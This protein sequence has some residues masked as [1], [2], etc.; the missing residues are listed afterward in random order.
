MDVS[1]DDFELREDGVT[2]TLDTFQEAVAPISI[3]L[4]IDAS[5]SMKP[6]AEAVKEAAK[7]VR[8]RVA[9]DR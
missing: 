3:V 2:Q 6:V 1:V 8:Q 4:A 9:P 5:G 7:R